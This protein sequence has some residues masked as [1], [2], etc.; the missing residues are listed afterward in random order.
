[1]PSVENK[2]PTFGMSTEVGYLR[3]ELSF[4]YRAIPPHHGALLQQQQ[5]QAPILILWLTR[6][7]VSYIGGRESQFTAECARSKLSHS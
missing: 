7:P 1:V 2:K 5:M 4:P 6:H 3:F